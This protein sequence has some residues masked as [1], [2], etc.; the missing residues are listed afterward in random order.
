VGRGS[1][2]VVPNTD[3]LHGGGMRRPEIELRDDLSGQRNRHISLYQI[4][5]RVDKSRGN[6]LIVS[7][8]D[9][10]GGG[11]MRQPGQRFK[12]TH[13]DLLGRRNKPI[14]SY[15][16]QMRVDVSGG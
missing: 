14:S 3:E 1:R 2:L 6:R 5:M 12:K 13:N 4:Q 10:L 9:E 11:G 7:N 15:Q 8:T 16:I